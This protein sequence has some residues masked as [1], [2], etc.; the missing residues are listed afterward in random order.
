[1]KKIIF[2]LLLI[3]SVTGVSSAQKLLPIKPSLE[4]IL[5]GGY[6]TPLSNDDFKNSF[7][8]FPGG[9]LEVVANV[10][11]SFGIYGNFSA[12]FLT[13]K[14][15]SLL[16]VTTTQETTYML[17]GSIGPRFYLNI[18]GNM[19][20]RVYGDLGWGIYGTRPGDLTTT[21]VTNPAVTTKYIFNAFSQMG[22]NV[23]AGLN[24][25][26]G[27]IGTANVALKYH[28]LFSKSG[29]TTVNTYTV[30]GGS[31]P[32]VYSGT[33]VD[34]DARSYFSVA[35]GLGFKIGI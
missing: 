8:A 18:P 19:L 22:F 6:G 15:Q 30:T 35:V 10:T 34:L 12:D 25:G 27:P 16:G 14:S 13:S 23:G 24:I 21:T 26:L 11:P 20:W 28:N 29:V 9:Q 4:I 2:T 7:Q 33:P 32:G 1:M 3:L 17:S 31:N 5:K